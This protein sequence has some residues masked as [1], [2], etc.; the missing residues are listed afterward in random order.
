MKLQARFVQLPL[1]FDAERLADEVGKLGEGAWLPHPQR[2]AGNDFLP[3]IS[4]RGEPANESFE[5]EMRPT[6][7]LPRCPYLIDV[8]ASLGVT[9]GR[10]RL[11]RLSGHAEVTPHVDVHYYWRDRMRVHVPIVT[12]PTVRFHC[13]DSEIHMAAG[14][15]WLFDTWSMHRVINDAERARIHLVVDTVGG[16]GFWNL[17]A[18]GRVPNQTSAAG[19]SPRRVEPNGATL[20]QLDYENFNLPLVMTPWEAREHITF[21]L[22]ELAPDGPALPATAQATTRF[23]HVWRALWSAHGEDQAGWP[24]YRRALDVFVRE[25]QGARA[26][27]LKLRNGGDL[28]QSLFSLVI[29]VALADRSRDDG[30]GESRGD[31]SGARPAAPRSAVLAMPMAPDPVFDRPVFIVNPPRSGST[32]LFETLAQAPGVYT[33]G[34]ESHGLIEGVAQ[35]GIGARQSNR[36]TA[37][38]VSPEVAAAL[39]ARFAGAL[40]DR[41]GV[42]PLRGARVRMLEKTPKNALRIPLLAAAFPEARFV[43][44]YRDPRQVLSSMMEGWELGR[45]VTYPDLVG[46]LGAHKWSFLLTPGWR[47]LIEL[48]LNQIVAAQWASTTQILLD[49]FEQIPAGRRAVARYDALIAAPGEEVARLCAAM[50]LEWDRVLGGQ[51]PIAAHTV[52]KPRDDKWRTRAAEIEAVLPAIAPTMERAAAMAAR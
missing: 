24:R 35:L 2:F 39:R 38:D 41:S 50:D 23:L 3:L 7:L 33:V 37:E 22:G 15:C 5:H 8:L 48:P 31:P 21:L 28:V 12:Q 25:L 13:G 42:P 27:T 52:S 51:L 6:P 1:E 44:L 46:W 9:L 45:F 29:N 47:D 49:D 4:A 20:A 11:M 32:L 10:T 30:G 16:E 36:L 26:E 17:A 34:G 14:E 18:R 40:R 19:W 43:Y